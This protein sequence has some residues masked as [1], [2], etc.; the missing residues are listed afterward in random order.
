MIRIISG[1]YRGRKINVPEGK[2]IKATSDEVREAIFNMLSSQLNWQEKT[3][4]DLYAGRGSFGFEALRR[5]ALKVIFVE[6]DSRK[7]G[8]LKKNIQLISPEAKRVNILKSRALKLITN[9]LYAELEYVIFIDPP[10]SSNEYE[11]LLENLSSQESIKK[12]SFIVLQSSF[13][14]KI[15]IPKNLEIIK[16]RRYGSK[17]IFI[18]LKY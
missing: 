10:F 5:G 1:I 17:R 4:I 2:N 13:K 9:F 14:R 16:H 8:T 12:G 15:E 18:L 3:V 6:M 11:P 7:I